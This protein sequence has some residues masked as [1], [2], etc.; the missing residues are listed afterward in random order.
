[1]ADVVNGEYVSKVIPVS[2]VKEN[3]E[4]LRPA[5]RQDPKYV[6]LVSSIKQ[7][8]VM[9]PIL[10]NELDRKDDEGRTLYSIINGVQRFNAAKDAGLTEIPVRVMP[11]D[12][13]KAELAQIH[14]NLHKIETRLAEYAKHLLR[15]LHRDPSLTKRQLA[16]QLG[17]NEK[18]LDDVLNLQ[19]LPEDAKELVN[20]GKIKLSNAF[21]LAAL[22]K[23]A[24]QDVATSYIGDAQTLPSQMFT[25][26][27][28]QHLIDLKKAKS[29]GK[30]PSKVGFS[31]VPTLQKIAVLQAEMNNPETTLALL[32]KHGFGDVPVEAIKLLMAFTLKLDPDSVEV[33]RAEYDARKQKESEEKAKRKQEREQKKAEETQKKL[34]T[35]G[36]V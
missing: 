31:P 10:V 2:V 16:M 33:A 18:W 5:K 35:L 32:R 8:G 26:K 20:E 19:H 17:K 13:A 27:V 12:E 24:G 15:V 14:A 4:A 6:E 25:P 29:Q 21:M 9:E 7:M 23:S 34:Q 36:T 22:A 30:D 11:W 3:P 28:K 1:M